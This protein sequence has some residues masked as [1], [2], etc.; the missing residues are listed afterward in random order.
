ML[1]SHHGFGV[2]DDFAGGLGGFGLISYGYWWLFSRLRVL[3]VEDGLLVEFY[4]IID[5]VL[6]GDLA[7]WG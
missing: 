4:D 5:I 6:N 2:L 7:W 1:F 3:E